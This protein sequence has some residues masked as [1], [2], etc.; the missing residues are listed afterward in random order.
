M[1]NTL[2]QT[3]LRW[4]LVF[5]ELPSSLISSSPEITPQTD[6]WFLFDDN[7]M[8]GS[9]SL[10]FGLLPSIPW[11]RLSYMPILTT[12]RPTLFSRSSV[13]FTTFLCWPVNVMVDAAYEFCIYPKRF[14]SSDPVP[15]VLASDEAF[16]I[17]NSSLILPSVPVPVSP[18]V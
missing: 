15:E 16:P 10:M 13:S 2:P 17:Q 14:P 7:S 12:I 1:G 5:R 8:R 4:D 6:F 3:P 9:A 18:V 11:V